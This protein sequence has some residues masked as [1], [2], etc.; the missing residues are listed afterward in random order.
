MIQEFWDYDETDKE[1]I[2]GI[3]DAYLKVRKA[4]LEKAAAKKKK[5][6]KK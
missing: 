3:S 1:K 2:S 4:E 5:K 6:K